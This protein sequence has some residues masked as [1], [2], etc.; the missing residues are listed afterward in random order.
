MIFPVLAKR[1]LDPN[2]EAIILFEMM[3]YL[4]ALINQDSED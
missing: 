2:D 3:I 1:V 4:Y